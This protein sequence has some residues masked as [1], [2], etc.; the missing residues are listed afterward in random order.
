MR[1]SPRIRQEPP[2]REWGSTTVSYCSATAFDAAGQHRYWLSI[3]SLL[4]GPLVPCSLGPL[5]PCSLVPCFF[6]H[7]PASGAHPPTLSWDPPPM[8]FCETVK[9]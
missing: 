7:P 4:F 1:L 6:T 8:P 3:F 2:R 5:V 9:L